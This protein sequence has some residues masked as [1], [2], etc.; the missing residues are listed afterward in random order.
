MSS[1]KSKKVVNLVSSL[2][3]EDLYTVVYWQAKE[4]EGE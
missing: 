4:R 3:C 1:N 2:V